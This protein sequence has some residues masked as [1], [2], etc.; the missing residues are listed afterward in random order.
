MDRLLKARK[1]A[2]DELRELLREQKELNAKVEFQKYHIAKLD[3][4]LGERE[5]AWVRTKRPGDDLS[6]PVLMERVLEAHPDGLQ[7]A[8]ILRELQKIG[9]ES[10]AKD[11]IGNL[12]TVLYRHRGKR[13]Q[14][15]EDGRW[16]LIK[17]GI[18]PPLGIPI[19][20]ELEK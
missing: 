5:R 1:E 14:K 9:F 6:I 10:A 20:K 16:Y 7:I 19:P 2:A 12:T 13:F 4:L 18:L 8:E 17:R 3:K 11:Q 15:K